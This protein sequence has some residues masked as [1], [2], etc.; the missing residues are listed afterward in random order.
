MFNCANTV[1]RELKE[2]MK[3]VSSVCCDWSVSKTT[4]INSIKLIGVSVTAINGEYCYLFTLILLT[5]METINWKHKQNCHSI[6][7]HYNAMVM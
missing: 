7:T 5:L 4:L 3:P 1:E 2:L 6:M